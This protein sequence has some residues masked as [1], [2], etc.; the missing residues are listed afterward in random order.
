MKLYSESEFPCDPATVWE[1]FS[2]DAFLARL[3]DVTQITQTVL[4][5]REENGV[6]VERVRNVSSKE[7]PSMMSRALGAKTLT[8]DQ[9]NRFDAARDRLEWSVEL[10][11]MSDKVDIRGVT[12]AQVRGSSTVRIVDGVC[13]VRVPLVGGRIEKVIVSEFTKSYAKASDI[14]REMIRGRQA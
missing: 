11:V 9:I 2:S 10:P 14:A 8:Y 7:L 13:T 4:D 1:V 6:L 12:T 3:R 5:R